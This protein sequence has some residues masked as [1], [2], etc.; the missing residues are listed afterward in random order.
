MVRLYYLIGCLLLLST[1]ASSQNR[2]TNYL[3]DKN[4]HPE[5]Y[6]IDYCR[7]MFQ[8]YAKSR[9]DSLRVRLLINL[10]AFYLLKWGEDKN[11]LD[12]ALSLGQEARQL[13]RLLKYR[14][15]EQDA[16]YWIGRT[17]VEAK[18]YP[19]VRELLK[20]LS[21]TPRIR[22][23]LQLVTYKLFTG[24]NT[25][26]DV[27]TAL[28]YARLALTQSEGIGSPMLIVHARLLLSECYLRKYGSARWKDAMKETLAYCRK[29]H[30]V[31]GAM[32]I[33]FQLFRYMDKDEALYDY[34]KAVYAGMQTDC[35]TSAERRAFLGMEDAV[36]KDWSIA[37]DK[38]FWINDLD[39]AERI[40]PYILK[41][42]PGRADRYPGF[43]DNLAFMA[44][45]KG[46]Y[47]QSLFYSLKAVKLIESGAA[48]SL[49]ENAYLYIGRAYFD[50][51]NIEQSIAYYLKGVAVLHKI[52]EYPN[53]AF[54][55]AIVKSY[56]KYNKPE[57]AL[58][59]L[60]ENTRSGIFH[61]TADY[62]YIFECFGNCY[63]AMSSY[64]KAEKY[65]LQSLA[66]TSS[67]RI[68]RLI[69]S[70][71][72]ARL[73]IQ[74]R[75][76]DKAASYLDE[77]EKKENK[78]LIPP[79][80]QQE[81]EL[82][83]FRVDSAKGSYLQAIG[84]LQQHKILNDSIFNDTRNKQ[85]EEL[86][87][88]YE[89]EKKDKDIQL[90][91]R[92]SQL[93]VTQLSRQRLQFEY[94]NERKKH[95]LDL[96]KLQSEQK[97]N[98]LKLAQYAAEREEQNIR[99]LNKQSQLQQ[100]DLRQ[101]R[102]LKNV[103]TGGSLM[104]LTL[105]GLIYSRYRQK[106]RTNRL[107]QA[108][109]AEI[110][111]RNQELKSLNEQQLRLLTEKEWLVKEIHHRVKN[112]LQM[113]I[114]LL[115]EQSEFLNNPSALNAIRESRERMQAI[116]IIHQKLYQMEDSFRISMRSYIN[117]LADNIRNSVDSADRIN[118]K[119]AIED[120]ALDISQSV[121][122]GLILNE[123]ITNAIKYA[124]P[125]HGKG[126][127]HISLHHTSGCQL[128][129]KIADNGKGLPPDMNAE[130]PSSLGFQLMRLFAE[131]LGADLFFANNNGLQI[132]LN[133]RIVE[134]K[135]ITPDKIM[136]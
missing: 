43:Y 54:I 15:G 117:D 109:Q 35:T 87:V 120:V 135:H 19:R 68:N 20:T 83:S 107:L 91:T 92:Q 25:A 21:D 40:Y 79:I 13:S 81:I 110:N 74:T 89:T 9:P 10:S 113:V 53:G 71:P 31:E 118:F 57:E 66:L 17:Y 108:Q 76:F 7:D 100:S 114:C 128:Q 101:T 49:S 3:L 126:D 127:V 111:R 95:E 5:G 122:L 39:K 45:Y 46:N 67:S 103:L 60:E 82:L 115:N 27:D 29:A 106:Q 33:C 134:H 42:F 64:E 86:K 119:L 12:S 37:A 48:K 63:F 75:Q 72:L 102:L 41:F 24:G 50:Q 11:D 132:I 1:Q 4:D 73:Y 123:A 69:V 98:E 38:A 59:F 70:V 61:T 97:D 105:L 22:V 93:Q 62:M 133:F 2:T 56:I 55:K 52:H 51:N 88:Q 58:S 77:L 36:L 44:Y 125:K 112:N 78:Y 16:E 80:V 94:D 65:L 34:M 130:D 124:Y 28:Y 26:Q 131:Q 121:P 84:H 23:M 90:L 18:D 85:F 47:S 8:Q 30:Y 116:A 104:L 14:R 136:A 32:K 99:L 129:L 96:V 6:P